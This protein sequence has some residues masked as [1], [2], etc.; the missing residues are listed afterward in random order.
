MLSGTAWATRE[1]NF[2]PVQTFTGLEQSLDFFADFGKL[3]NKTTNK[4]KTWDYDATASPNMCADHTNLHCRFTVTH[5][6]TD[7]HTMIINSIFSQVLP[8]QLQRHTPDTPPDPHITRASSD[9]ASG[10]IYPVDDSLWSHLHMPDQPASC[11]PLSEQ[12]AWSSV[13]ARRKQGNTATSQENEHICRYLLLELSPEQFSDPGNSKFVTYDAI[14]KIMSQWHATLQR[15]LGTT[16]TE[17]RKT[18]SVPEHHRPIHRSKDLAANVSELVSPSPDSETAKNDTR[19]QFRHL[20][21]LPLH[22]TDRGAQWPRMHPS[23]QTRKLW[24]MV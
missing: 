23:F 14:R 12:N 8:L 1:I 22:R 4:Y 15:C 11:T 6:A 5:V 18:L 7:N 21:H 2:D 10:Y 20:S 9:G 3:K 16:I 24:W 17:V 13:H 19:R